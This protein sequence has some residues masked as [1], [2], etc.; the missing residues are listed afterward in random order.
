LN[1]SSNIN[2]FAAFTR[3][4]SI[5]YLNNGSVNLDNPSAP[6]GSVSA[7]PGTFGIILGISGIK[8]VAP[9]LVG[10]WDIF[11]FISRPVSS[12]LKPRKGWIRFMAMIPAEV[13]MTYSLLGVYT[14]AFGF[15]PQV[16]EV[17]LIKY[18]ALNRGNGQILQP[19]L[20]YNTVVNI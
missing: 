15:F 12:S 20:V 17:V 19:A 1:P 11:I 13:T 16:G 14:N 10:D 4:H 7:Y 5:R 6:Q 9:T 18:L 2:G 8:W 3:W